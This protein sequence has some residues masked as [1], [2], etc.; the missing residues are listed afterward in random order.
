[1]LLF[2]I[3]WLILEFF[4]LTAEL[5]VLTFGLFFGKIMPYFFAHRA[6]DQCFAI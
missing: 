6:E 3:L 4:L 1:M 5:S 2:Q